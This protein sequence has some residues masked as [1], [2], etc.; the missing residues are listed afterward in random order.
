LLPI[1]GMD[2]NAHLKDGVH[3]FLYLEVVDL[4]FLVIFV[5]EELEQAVGL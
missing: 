5:L 2:S 1:L 4:F 3:Q